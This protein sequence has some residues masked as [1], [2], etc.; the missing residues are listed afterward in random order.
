MNHNTDILDV[1]AV[2]YFCK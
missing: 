2:F 1:L